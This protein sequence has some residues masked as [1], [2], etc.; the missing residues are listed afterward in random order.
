M[1]G[2]SLSGRVAV[3]YLLEARITVESQSNFYTGF[4]QNISEGGVFVSMENPPPVGEVVRLQVHLDDGMA[5]TASG[6]VRWHR[7]DDA[8]GEVV[9]AGVQF[10]A[11][12]PDATAALQGMLQRAQQEPL[13]ME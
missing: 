6:Q 5:V 11:L 7:I 2:A 3:R 13:L 4:S 10:M 12:D 9:G 8:T 1:K